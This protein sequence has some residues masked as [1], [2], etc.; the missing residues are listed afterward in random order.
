MS[1]PGLGLRPGSLHARLP[2]PRRWALPQRWAGLIEAVAQ[3]SWALQAV[4]SSG[5]RSPAMAKSTGVRG[6][7]SALTGAQETSW[8]REM[9]SASGWV[10]VRE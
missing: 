9:A 4:A 10:R 1:E 3:R 2:A 5:P 8:G 7:A 6:A